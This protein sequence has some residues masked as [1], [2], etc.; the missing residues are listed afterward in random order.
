MICRSGRVWNVTFD[1]SR[2][3]SRDEDIAEQKAYFS[4][5]GEDLNRIKL[6]QE[7]EQPEEEESKVEEN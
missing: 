3:T 7:E 1:N 6:G 5:S 4:R 2:E